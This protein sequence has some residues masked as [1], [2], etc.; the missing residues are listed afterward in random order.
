MVVATLKAICPDWTIPVPG[1][2]A[3]LDQEKDSWVPYHISEMI[4]K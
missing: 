1:A 4:M 3:I 2:G